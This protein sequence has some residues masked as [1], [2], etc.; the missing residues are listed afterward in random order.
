MIYIDPPY[1]TGKD[2]VYKDNFSK[3]AQEEL[4]ESG[5]KDEYNQRLVANPET[6]GRYHSDWLSMMYPRLKLAR[7]LLT[8]NGV[9][10]ISIDDNE[11]HTLK[12]VC[13]D[14]F[15]EINFE[16]HIHWRRRHNQPNDKTKLIGLVAEHILVYAKSS[17]NLKKSGVGKLPLTGSF[18]NPDN[19]PRGEWATKPWKV[20]SDQSGSRY[21]IVTPTGKVYDEE[22]MGGKRLFKNYLMTRE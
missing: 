5:Q 19:D 11:V 7:N 16:G 14:I 21:K 4:I 20:G 1:N 3:D 6:A 2:F 13:D 17:E 18:S 10:F 8:E 12:K 9:I 15:G 22:W